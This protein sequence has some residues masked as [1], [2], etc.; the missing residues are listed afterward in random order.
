MNFLRESTGDGKMIG[1]KDASSVS[2]KLSYCKRGGSRNTLA[3]VN[4][5]AK[6]WRTRKIRGMNIKTFMKP[7]F[8]FLRDKEL[9]LQT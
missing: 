7:G 5:Q 6:K 3:C 2:G 4:R 1:R 8:R 9:L